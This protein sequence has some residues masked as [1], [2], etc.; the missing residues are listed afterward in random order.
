MKRP[1]PPLRAI[2]A[3]E[4]FGR[5]RSVTAAAAELGVSPG[6]I[7][8]QLRKAEEAVGAQLLERR[9]RALNMTSWGRTYFSAISA[10]FDQIREAGE[11]LDRKLLERALTMSCLPSLASKWLA[12]LLIDWQVHHPGTTVR[13]LGAEGESQLGEDQ[14]DFRI[15]YGSK[16]RGYD[17]F[18]EMFSDWVVPACAPALVDKRP[19]HTPADVLDGPLLRIEWAPDHGSPPNWED[20]ASA[21]GQSCRRTPGDVAFSMSS[22]AID[23]A[24]NGRGFVLA[25]LAMAGDDI[26]A[27]RL[28]IPFAVPLRLSEP[29]FL[30]WDQSALH[31]QD[32][33]HLKAWVLAAA[34]RQNRLR[35][36]ILA[37]L[38]S[39]EQASD[40]PGA[41]R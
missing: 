21:I 16:A 18:T 20:W 36:T 25:Q 10:G 31:K 17:H 28:V 13:L 4:A 40:M 27:G 3:F 15:T 38:P 24:V 7:S 8:Q 33:A 5:L 30:A 9:G 35:S 1:I 29:Y 26:A 2:Q 11:A 14:V 19:C 6:A 37:S 23:A 41:A 32:G 34:N 12:P 39:F 22:A